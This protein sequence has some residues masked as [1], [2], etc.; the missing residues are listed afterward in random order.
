MEMAFK[1]SPEDAKTRVLLAIWD[2]GG[3]N[4]KVAKGQL[5]LARTGEKVGDY[6]PIFDDLESEGAIVWDKKRIGLTSAGVKMLSSQLQRTDFEFGGTQVGS[7]VANALLKWI[8]EGD[9]ALA[10]VSTE[11]NDSV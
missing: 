7:W 11:S 8:R 9:S 10:A 6:N 1:G 4:E 5:R 2:R 3:A